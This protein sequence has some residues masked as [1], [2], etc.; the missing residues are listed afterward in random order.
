[1]SLNKFSAQKFLTNQILNHFLF[2]QTET[3][4]MKHEKEVNT[5]LAKFASMCKKYV[6]IMS[7]EK[8]ANKGT[9]NQFS[10]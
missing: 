4:E 1:M 3:E 7:S 5:R 2:S 9:L 6:E 10:L 8:H